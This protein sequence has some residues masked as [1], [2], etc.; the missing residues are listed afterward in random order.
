MKQKPQER[1]K[2]TDAERHKRFVE[3]IKKTGVS[4]KITDFDNAFIKLASGMK[5][6]H[7]KRED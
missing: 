6:K 7:A 5:T 2:L 1:S 4:D 3:T